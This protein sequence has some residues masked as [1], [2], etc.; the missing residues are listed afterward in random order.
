MRKDSSI[1]HIKCL[2]R[3]IYI[4]I[5]TFRQLNEKKAYIMLDKVDYTT[6]NLKLLCLLTEH[7]ILRFV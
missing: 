3:G 2:T 4:F 5:F 7:F 6:T 1:H